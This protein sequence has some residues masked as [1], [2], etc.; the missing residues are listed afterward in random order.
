MINLCNYNF[1]G[2]EDALN[3]FPTNT[4]RLNEVKIQNGIYDQIDITRNANKDKGFNTEIPQWGFGTIIDCDFSNGIG[5]GNVDFTLSQ[6][7]AIRIKRRK[8]SKIQWFRSDDW[9]TIKEI[10]IN[11]EADLN[12]VIRDYFVPSFE[13]FEY[14]L[15]PILNGVEGEYIIGSISTQFDGVFISDITNSF[16]LDKETSYPNRTSIQNIGQINTLGRKYPII[17]TNSESD[18]ETGSVSGLLIGDINHIEDRK[19]TVDLMDDF[20]AFLK[21]KKP[22]IIKDWNGKIW[23]VRIY[24]NPSISYD[25]RYGMGVGKVNFEWIEQ[26]KYD[27]EEDLLENGFIESTLE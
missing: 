6:L 16:I 3:P 23:L 8:K 24:G 21:N 17:I 13:E 5:A 2:D 15:V 12:E 4:S 9:I 25:N 19:E 10:P 22:K 7:T 18:Y 14:A 27:N 20:L 26:G 1:C 11:S